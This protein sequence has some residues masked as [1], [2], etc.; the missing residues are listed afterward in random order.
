MASPNVWY[1][2]L[3]QTISKMGA[4]LQ[5]ELMGTKLISL[6]IEWCETPKPACKGVAYSDFAYL[7]DK[8]GKTLLPLSNRRPQNNIYVGIRRNLLDTVDPV[9]DAAIDRV[10]NIYSRT[11]W[12]NANG[13]EFCQAYDIIQK[14][15]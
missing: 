2:A 11:F 10:W 6:M 3:A 14:K 15:L 9:L 5:S 4:Q 8:D 7:Y 12:A 1:L 13:L